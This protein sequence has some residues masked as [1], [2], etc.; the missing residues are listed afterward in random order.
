MHANDAT[1]TASQASSARF[2]W[3]AHV[4]ATDRVDGT[5]RPYDRN[6]CGSTRED[7]DSSPTDGPLAEASAQGPGDGKGRGQRCEDGDARAGGVRRDQDAGEQRPERLRRSREQRSRRL[8]T[9]EE[10]VR[11]SRDPIPVDDGIGDRKRETLD[12]DRRGQDEHARP[13]EE[14]HDAEAEIELGQS[15]RSRR[16]PLPGATRQ[17]RADEDAPAEGGNQEPDFAAGESMSSGDDDQDEEKAGDRDV[18]DGVE[19]GRVAEVGIRPDVAEPLGES[20][21]HRTL[22]ALAWL[23]EPPSHREQR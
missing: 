16:E 20:S 5:A 15:N 14:E 3:R 7:P 2:G 1:R 19:K 6:A 18:A 8:D 13:D 22:L 17:A 23:L 4:R 12:D 9:A 21:P 10:V 11:C